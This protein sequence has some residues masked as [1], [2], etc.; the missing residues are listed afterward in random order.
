MSTTKRWWEREE[1][2]IS[3]GMLTVILMKRESIHG[4]KR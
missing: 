4:K 3:D 1:V 2:I